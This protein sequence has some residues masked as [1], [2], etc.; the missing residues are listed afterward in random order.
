MPSAFCGSCNFRHYKPQFHVTQ[1]GRPTGER[2]CRDCL[3]RY[4]ENGTPFQCMV[5][6]K[7]R[8]Q[9]AFDRNQWHH[10]KL[11]TRRCVD[12]PEV[13]QCKRCGDRKGYSCFDMEQ[14]EMAGRAG[15]SKGHC[16]QCWNWVH[17]AKCPGCEQELPRVNFSKEAFKKTWEWSRGDAGDQ[18]AKPQS[19]CKD[20]AAKETSRKRSVAQKER[21]RKAIP[22]QCTLVDCHHEDELAEEALSEWIAEQKKQGF[23]SGKTGRQICNDCFRAKEE[24]DKH[25]CSKCKQEKAKEHILDSEWGKRCEVRRCKKCPREEEKHKCSNCKQEKVKEDFLDSEWDRRRDVRRCKDCPWEEVA[26]KHKCSNCKQDKVKQD[27]LESEWDRRRDVRRCKDCPRKE[28]AEKHKCSNCKQDRVRQDFLQSEWDRR[29]DVRRCKDCPREEVAEKHKCS[30]C[31]QDRVRQDFLESEWN[32]SRDVRRCKDCP[33]EEVAEKHKCSNC[34]QDRVRQDFIESEW[35]RRRD[36]RRCKDCPQEKEVAK[37][38]NN[39]CGACGGEM[40]RGGFRSDRAWRHHKKKELTAVCSKCAQK[41][42]SAPLPLLG[43]DEELAVCACP[44]RQSLPFSS[45]RAAYARMCKA[46]S[47]ASLL[48]SE[49]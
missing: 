36:V 45:C 7:W 3:K 5:C 27:F 24:V 40:Q 12:C 2:I 11:S 26:E 17:H 42:K 34:K 33:R 46:C 39:E 8:P 6:G 44:Y 22:W 38:F 47:S 15:G 25:K 37:K 14:L 18:D 41:G 48:T 9:E 35:D 43:C 10:G 49:S 28:V 13:R 1:W 19:Q 16:S 4:K 29:R 23:Q 31:K 30:N 21:P 32:R 20:C